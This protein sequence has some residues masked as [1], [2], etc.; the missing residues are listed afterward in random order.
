MSNK[1]KDGEHFITD[2][3]IK[4]VKLLRDTTLS[5][6]AA[7]WCAGIFIVLFL[8]LFLPWTQNIRSNG[9]LTTY[10]PQD[11]PQELQSIIAGRIEQ[12]YVQE[13]QFVNKGDTIVR[14][15][16]VKEKFLDTN[17]LARMQ[18][19][20]NAKKGSR[21]S[22]SEKVT[23]LSAQIRAL[24]AGQ[25][26]SLQKAR[27]KLK[28][29]G[30]KVTADSS[31]AVAA[32]A[33]YDIAVVQQRRADSLLAK[34]LISLT[35]AER[36]RLKVQEANAKRIATENK[37]L[38]SRNEI[39]NA[40]IELSS[41]EAEYI[42]KISKAESD[43]NSALSYL[44]ET[45]GEI[46]KMNNEYINMRIRQGFY[47]V[48]APQAG[49]VVQAKV[50]GVGE[51]VKE[52]EVIVSI[53]PANPNL[54]VALYVEP[55]DIPLLAK[56]R[57]VRLQF[58]GWPA[59]VFSGWPNY[60]FGTFGGVVA[61]IDNIDTKGKY[62]ILVIPDPE[63]EPWPVQLRVGSGAYGWALLNDVPVWY[64]L[65]RQ[66]NGFPP[67]YMGHK[68]DEALEDYNKAKAATKQD[69]EKK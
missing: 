46:S 53:M 7:R 29:A 65:W 18:E 9:V 49:Y 19:Q 42:D 30:F 12:W 61:V 27:N 3:E 38:A 58:D 1:I 4:A 68:K 56:G 10:K 63:E 47:F 22:A 50:A 54:A 11:R 13:G 32:M 23:A 21:S 34:G 6:A 5:K 25:Q 69:E 48:T 26:L 45:E 14:L 24:Q 8:T 37:L 55:M 43:L 57:K 64:E 52:G 20:I 36:R 33:D 66:L 28:Q 67:D 2:P 39:I 15:S 62:R 31:D 44:Y 51:T 35:D 60:S 59:L 16:E 17:L 41:I 40:N